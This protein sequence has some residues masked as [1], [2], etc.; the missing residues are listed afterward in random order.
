ME[1]EN[2][3]LVETQLAVFDLEIP[4]GKPEFGIRFHVFNRGSGWPGKAIEVALGVWDFPESPV[5]YPAMLRKL[6]DKLEALQK[7]AET[8]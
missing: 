5:D 3:G 4:H 7:E 2:R 6:A 1:A 8:W